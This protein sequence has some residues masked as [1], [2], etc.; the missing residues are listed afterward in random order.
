VAQAIYYSL[1]FGAHW[2]HTGKKMTKLII[3]MPCYNEENTLEQTL[4][5]LPTSIEGID[6]IKTLVIDDGSTDKTAEVAKACGVDYIVRNPRNLGL[7]ATYSVGI[8]TSLKLG[9]DIIV[10]TDGDNQYRGDCV[11]DLAS[12]IL[13]GKS[14]IV[15]GCRPIEEISDF[16]WLKKKLQ[17]LGSYVVSQ[18]AGI[19][20]PDTTSG[21]RAYSRKAA[22]SL[23]VVSSFTY[24]IET[25][26]QAGRRRIPMVTVPI[27]TN[28]KTRDSVLFKSMR[29]YIVKSMSTIFLI[30][31]QVKPL[32]TFGIIGF[33]SLFAGF[34]LGLRFILIMVTTTDIGFD[35][36]SGHV[37]SLIL[38]AV[39]LLFGST[40]FLVGLLADQIGANR[41]LLEEIYTQN[42][43]MAYEKSN[44]GSDISNLVYEKGNNS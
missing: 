29:Q 13:D 31:T 25:I 41:I 28:K 20:I 12:P 40:S 27:K 5:D 9:A 38:A 42:R 17:R 23:M 11:K 30:S 33:L 16:S 4:K 26:I 8:E 35:G 22:M 21:F 14:E 43:S 39:F 2:F 32:R 19:S 7:A 18:V 15:I 44:S 10:N 24:T 6:E 37:Q 1:I 34:L 3:Q 36:Q